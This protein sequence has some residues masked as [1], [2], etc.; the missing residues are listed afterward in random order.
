MASS[1]SSSSSN[2][3]LII[4]NALDAYT[5]K[6]RT[7]N[8]LLVLAH[9]PAAKLQPCDTPSAILTVLQSIV[10]INSPK[11]AVE[12][13][14]R[15]AVIHLDRPCRPAPNVIGCEIMTGGYLFGFAQY[16]ETYVP[17]PS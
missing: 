11:A 12:L 2:F 6:K 14:D 16:G 7:K 9:P 8:D 17:F 13:L 10:V 3:Q 5:G 4:N 15:R 1:S